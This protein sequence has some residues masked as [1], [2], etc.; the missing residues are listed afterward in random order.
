MFY[1]TVDDEQNQRGMIDTWLGYSHTYR[2]N[3]G[4]FY[5]E[6]NL[7]S[8][9]YPVLMP[10]KRRPIILEGKDIR[11]ILLD[12]GELVY[13]QNTTLHAGGK[14]WDLSAYIDKDL[15]GAIGRERTLV[16]FGAYVIIF[17]EGCYANIATTASEEQEIGTIAETY[18]MPEGKTATY[19]IT[20]SDGVALN[21]TISQ[22]AP[23]NPNNGEYWLCTLPNTMGLNIW[24]A[25]NS[26][27]DAVQ[28]CYISITIPD[29]DFKS[30]FSEGDA[31]CMN[32]KMDDVNDGSIIRK[33]TS[34]TMV[35]DGFLS[36]GGVFVASTTETSDPTWALT[37]SRKLPKLDYVCVAHNR[38]WGCYYGV[39]DDGT[40]INE[41]HSCKLGD[42]KNWYVFDGIAS[43][44]Y[45]VQV[46]ETG[47]WTGCIA[48]NNYPTFFKEAEIF[49]VFGSQPSNYQ[50]STLNVRGVQEGSSKSLV[51]LGDYLI[52]KSP[53]DICIYDGSIP[54]S[55]SQRKFGPEMYYDGVAGACL[56]KYYISMED[57]SGNAY[58]F[59]YDTETGVWHR[60]DSFRGIY[61]DSEGKFYRTDSKAAMFTA[62]ENGQIFALTLG[63][64]VTV[65]GS[66][67]YLS[68]RIYGIGHSDSILFRGAKYEE[69]RVEWSAETG[70]FGYEMPDY[71]R[72][73]RVTVRAYI[74]VD[75]SIIV[76][77]SYDDGS[78]Q[79]VGTMQG[80]H[81]TQQASFAFAPL[82]CDH[83]QIK[84][85][86][87]GECRI[88]SMATSYTGGA[89][90]DGEHY[91]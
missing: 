37:I 15:D 76:A 25:N 64:K 70:V 88:Y 47:R 77:V 62:S 50:M 84:F 69:D 86:G 80:R 23:E 48:Y 27:W 33:L 52:Y 38:I 31:V 45:V 56:G 40:M 2:C 44:S 91:H 57:A 17:P 35:I 87:K 13:L 66:D 12:N 63:G 19:T 82:R 1:K 60:E 53:S 81:N 8:D 71:K 67:E 90:D 83:Y 42:F 9:G 5:D 78:Y 43:D 54:T 61:E 10:R 28:S 39:G 68:D 21:P 79:N 20:D 24:D 49:R 58:L 59:V 32:T 11:G 36:V 85:T 6:E 22:K 18:T 3:A 89:E 29:A 30:R 73:N 51:Q 65:N 41:I 4:E 16:R 55:I 7:S 34:D 75:C 26:E 72:V 46:G 14:E 74:P